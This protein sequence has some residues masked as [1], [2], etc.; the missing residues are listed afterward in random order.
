MI[1]TI[2]NDEQVEIPLNTEISKLTHYL[3]DK[4][5]SYSDYYT[6]NWNGMAV[7][8]NYTVVNYKLQEQQI[9]EKLY[10]VYNE[11]ANTVTN[12]ETDNFAKYGINFP[13]S[14]L[15]VNFK[16]T[17]RVPDNSS[18]AY[19]LPPDLG[20]FELF[21]SDDNDIELPMYQKEAMWLNFDGKKNVALKIGVGNVNAITGLPWTEGNL[22]QNPQ[23]YVIC[24]KQP[25]LDGIKVNSTTNTKVN[26][27]YNGEFSRT[28]QI[29]EDLVR[30]F[31]AVPYDSK[32]SIEQQL[33][34]K[35]LIENIEGGLKFEVFM[36]YNTDFKV[37]SIEQKKFLDI[38]DK[39]SSLDNL[40]FY[41]KIKNNNNFTLYDFGIR[42]NDK[43]QIGK[44]KEH[45]QIFVRTLSGN[46]LTLNVAGNMET[47]QVK[48]LVEEAVG[49]PVH[50]QRLIY[51]G[52]SLEKDRLLSDY[53][54]GPSATIHLV[55]CLRGG[56]GADPRLSKMSLAAGGLIKQKIY[57]DSNNLDCYNQTNYEKCKINIVNSLQYSD[58][59]P[60][61][62]ISAQTYNSYSYPFYELYDED[63][64]SIQKIKE[65]MFDEILSLK[66][67]ESKNNV[68]G[69]ECCI[70]MSFYTNIN[71]TSCGHGCCS[72]CFV[73]LNEKTTLNCHLCRSDVKK[74]S[75]LSGIDSIDNEDF[76]CKNTM[77]AMS[78][79]QHSIENGDFECVK[80]DVSKMYSMLKYCKK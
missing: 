33:K 15:N 70:C 71:F 8:N 51:A 42:E 5:K 2:I 73:K 49:I 1:S 67:H 60:M 12:T 24:S 65:S 52:R 72:D 19:P 30:Q 17:L 48:V 66:E 13:K 29:I 55:L 74:V 62:P 23:N 39:V 46:T 44:I 69:E 21:K 25:W 40:V 54:I 77:N 76:E 26:N 50:Q 35:N 64:V 61:T 18:T 56:G 27:E 57:L 68:T 47:E 32:S 22:T 4:L 43:I 3:S 53:K 28:D 80:N 10:K 45:M 34:E 63:V 78:S 59:M 41:E 16:R 58:K 79:M 36:M 6:A 7:S 31:V 9:G 37:Y 38:N 11:H 75:V 20:N 14:G